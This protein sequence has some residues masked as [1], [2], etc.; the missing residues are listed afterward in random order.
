[1]EGLWVMRKSKSVDW[2]FFGPEKGSNCGRGGWQLCCCISLPLFLLLQSGKER[3]GTVEKCQIHRKEQ[4]I[5]RQGK[6]TASDKF[7][8]SLS[9][10]MR[11]PE[12]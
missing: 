9:L 10:V 6:P 4:H 2:R 11:I 3:A 1:M 7:C 5:H 8:I 12:N